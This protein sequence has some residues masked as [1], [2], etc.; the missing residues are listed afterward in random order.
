MTSTARSNR[1]EGLATQRGVDGLRLMHKAL[2]LDYAG[3]DKDADAAYRQAVEVMAPDR[4]SPMPMAASLPVMVASTKP[5]RLP[6]RRHR[7]SRSTVAVTA[8]RDIAAKK[9]LQPLIISPADGMAEALFGIAASLNDRRSSKSQFFTSNV[10]LYLRPDF[11]LGR[12]LLRQPLR[13][14]AESTKMANAIYVRLQPSS[15]YYAMTQVQA[16]INDGRLNQPEAGVT[17]LR[18]WW[19]VIPK[20]RTRTCGRRSAISSA[21]PSITPKRPP[22]TTRAVAGMKDGDRRLSAVY[23]ARGVSLSARNR[24]MNADRRPFMPATALSYAV[25]ASA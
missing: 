23:Y 22:H 14:C 1:F 8:L 17:K 13:A 12:V 19:S 6:A 24:W 15:P 21:V 5:S 9:T 2:I 7:E 10:A 18:L 16:A 11:D 20:I 3:N 4:G 25:A